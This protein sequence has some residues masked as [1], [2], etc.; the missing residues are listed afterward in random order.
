MLERVSPFFYFEAK[1]FGGLTARERERGSETGS[2]S[3][4]TEPNVVACEGEHGSARQLSSDG[5]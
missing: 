5:L 4:L 2:N 3:G 1:A